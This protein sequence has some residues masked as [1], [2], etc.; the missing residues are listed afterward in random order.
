M[1]MVPAPTTSRSASA[2][3]PP[4]LGWEPVTRREDEA[5]AHPYLRAL[6][7]IG[8]GLGALPILLPLLYVVVA[9][10]VLVATAGA[11]LFLLVLLV[12]GVPIAFAWRWT[13]P[14]HYAIA[15][16]MLWIPMTTVYTLVFLGGPSL[17]LLAASWLLV[18]MYGLYSLGLPLCVV[19]LLDWARIL[20]SRR[21][22]SLREGAYAGDWRVVVAGLLVYMAGF[23]LS[24]VACG[25]ALLLVV[26]VAFVMAGFLMSGPRPRRRAA[27][28]GLP[29]VWP[30]PV[31]PRCATPLVPD[32]MAGVWYCPTCGAHG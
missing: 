10:P 30:P 1:G 27:S 24:L 31:C 29:P 18:V 22:S 23:G 15:Y 9:A 19:A 7:G 14:G 12:P 3:R 32:P 25:G 21:T 28:Y 4:D 13:N 26:G 5:Y 2:R 17:A 6:A 20:S 16:L 11:L 8:C